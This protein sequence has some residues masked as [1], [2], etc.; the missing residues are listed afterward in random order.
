MT[1]SE[2]LFEA[3]AK[4]KGNVVI[5]FNDTADTK[6]IRA[7]QP[8]DYLLVSD[9][10]ISFAEVKETKK[11]TFA[12]SAVRPS[13][14]LHADLVTKKKQKYTFYLLSLSDNK[15]YHVPASVLLTAK[16]EGRKSI[17]FEELKEYEVHER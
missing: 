13:Q 14:W 8:A 11:T 6:E 1:I 3:Y 2:T 5:R 16:R 9:K 4:A 7:A 12:F 10:G 17:K 15:W